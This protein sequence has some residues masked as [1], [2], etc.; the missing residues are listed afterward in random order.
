MTRLYVGTYTR[1]A[2]Y[3]ATTNGEGLYVLDYDEA[4]GALTNQAG[5]TYLLNAAVSNSARRVH[6]PQPSR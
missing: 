4:S 6:R 5:A 3:L 1:P 2:P